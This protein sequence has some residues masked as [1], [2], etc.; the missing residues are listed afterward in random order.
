MELS[1][2][3]CTRLSLGLDHSCLLNSKG[4]LYSWGQG[5]QGQLGHTENKVEWSPRLLDRYQEYFSEVSCGYYFTAA[6]TRKDPSDSQL[7]HS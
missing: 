5:H 1:G 2:Q 7:T 3:D 6:I 4:D